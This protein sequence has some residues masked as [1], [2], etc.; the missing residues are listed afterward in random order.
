[1]ADRLFGSAHGSSS[2][3]GIWSR[4]PFITEKIPGVSLWD[5]INPLSW[6]TRDSTP[7]KPQS[8]ELDSRIQREKALRR[9]RWLWY[10]GS[11]GVMVAYLFASGLVSIDTDGLAVTVLREEDEDEEVVFVEDDEED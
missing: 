1:M 8:K 3:E 4:I 11:A 5:S 10:L 7:P 6:F 2:T 9:G